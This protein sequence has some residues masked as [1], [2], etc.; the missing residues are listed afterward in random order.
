VYEGRLEAAII[1]GTKGGEVLWQKIKLQKAAGQAVRLLLQ[2][3]D[4]LKN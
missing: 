3:N 4:R 1:D 2:K